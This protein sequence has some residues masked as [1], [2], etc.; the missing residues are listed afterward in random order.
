M[1]SAQDIK[2]G[3]GLGACW[4]VCVSQASDAPAPVPK[5]MS[6]AMHLEG[7]VR[8]W[9]QYGVASWATYALHLHEF[10][11]ANKPLCGCGLVCQGWFAVYPL[12]TFAPPS[13]FRMVGMGG[14]EG[15]SMEA[16]PPRMPSNRG[17][18]T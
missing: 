1:C 12:K 14:Q 18:H 7:F 8:R 15:L 11:T 13:H 3:G 5:A 9:L 16:S 6:C 2:G 4:G 17:F 10:N